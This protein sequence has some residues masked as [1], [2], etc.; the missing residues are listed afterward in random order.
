[1]E[2]TQLYGVRFQRRTHLR[3]TEDFDLLHPFDAV[4]R[5]ELIILSG[6][7]AQL[8]HTRWQMLEG[9]QE[10]LQANAFRIRIAF[11]RLTIEIT[12]ILDLRG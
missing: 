3:V 6:M 1:M 8:R 4:N 5:I 12:T 2:R 9:L 7:A 11:A 10:P